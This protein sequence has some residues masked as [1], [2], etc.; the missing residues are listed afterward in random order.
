MKKIPTKQIVA[1]YRST[2]RENFAAS[3]RLEGILTESTK[4]GRTSPMP[5]KATLKRKYASIKAA[6]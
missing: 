3:Q 5:D 6:S 4:A 2:R 1:L